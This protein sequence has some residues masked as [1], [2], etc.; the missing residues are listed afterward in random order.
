MVLCPIKHHYEVSLPTIYTYL[1]RVPGMPETPTR[2]TLRQF[3]NDVEI[4][5]KSVYEQLLTI[6]FELSF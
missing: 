3:K 6:F 4:C 5:K 1:Y 2:R